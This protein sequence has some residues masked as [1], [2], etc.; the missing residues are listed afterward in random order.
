MT[1]EYVRITSHEKL[2]GERN[3]LYVQMELLSSE[4]N[5]VSYNRLRKKENQLKIDLKS[6]IKEAFDLIKDLD[7][8]L[9]KVALPKEEE[10]HI[11]E[12]PTLEDS[13]KPLT[14][15]EELIQIRKKLE[16]LKE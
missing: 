4:K 1:E 10:I 9:P 15:D 11:V 8:I 14:L 16:K 3:L 2:F 7:K 6:R 5:L 13:W 12:K